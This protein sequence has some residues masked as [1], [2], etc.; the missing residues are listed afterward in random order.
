MSFVAAEA[1]P[2]GRPLLLVGNEVSQTLAV[3]EIEPLRTRR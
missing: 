3:F 2:T 1:S